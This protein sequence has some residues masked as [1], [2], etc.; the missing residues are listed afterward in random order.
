MPD[1]SVSAAAAPAAP[2]GGPGRCESP[3]FVL[4]A[5][6]S[7]STLLRFILDSHPRLACPPETSIAAACA[8]LSLSCDVLEHADDE[9]RALDAPVAVGPEALAAVRDVVGRAYDS[10]LGRRGKQRWCDKSLDNFQYTDLITQL[11]PEAKFICLYRH[12]MDVVASAVEACPWGLHRFG[13]DAFAAQ[14]VG[15]SV[16][17]VGSYWMSTVQAILDFEERHPEACY[18]VRYE[19]LVSAPEETAAGIF[20]FLGEA[21]VPGITTECFDIPHEGNG[22][23]DE[24]LW[25]TSGVSADSVGRGVVVPADALPEGLRLAINGALAKLG[26]RTVEGD[27]N[28]APGATDPRAAAVPGDMARGGMVAGGTGHDGTGHDGTAHDGTAPGDAT[29]GASDASPGSADASASEATRAA[30]A[31][32]ADRIAAS[33][34]GRANQVVRRW[35]ALAGQTIRIVV[36]NSAQD[37]QTLTWTV[38]AGEA[39]EAGANGHSPAGGVRHPQPAGGTAY[40]TANGNGTAAGPTTLIASPV[41]WAALLDGTTNAVTELTA[42]RLRCVNIR[43]KHRIRSDELHAFAWLLGMARTPLTRSES[44]PALAAA[45]A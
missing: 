31:A 5:S 38:P 6:R 34:A 12:C 23:G 17:A 7:G 9:T 35:P 41:T 11:Y 29:A 26:Y 22:S 14:N 40:G 24:K 18:R 3:V 4:T 8:Q 27:W 33:G 44:D 36:A 1:E 13:L 10:Y 43:D 19:D 20:S 42:G 32:L 2:A 37:R 30:A 45:M 28:S 16:A 39:G 15:N 25:F 21:Q